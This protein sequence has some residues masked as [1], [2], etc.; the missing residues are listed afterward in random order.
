MRV[1]SRNEE[2]ELEEE[3]DGERWERETGVV[4]EEGIDLVP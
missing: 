3:R 2:V 4:D 1:G